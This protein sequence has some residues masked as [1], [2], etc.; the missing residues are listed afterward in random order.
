M[1]DTTLDPDEKIARLNQDLALAQT[2]RQRALIYDGIQ[3]LRVRLGEAGFT[4]Y[5]HYELRH[6][7]SGVTYGDSYAGGEYVVTL[8]G[9][10]GRTRPVLLRLTTALQERDPMAIQRLAAIIVAISAGAEHRVWI[11]AGN[12][13]YGIEA[14]VLATDNLEDGSTSL[15]FGERYTEADQP[16][17]E[18]DPA[19]DDPDPR[20]YD[21]PD[22][23]AEKNGER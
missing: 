7:S 20:E 2:E 1:T 21:G 16:A 15:L 12:V 17:D 19:D 10:G 11:G 13:V 3:A 8:S 14:A 23:V 5:K 6:P 9:L 22:T 18:D 4:T